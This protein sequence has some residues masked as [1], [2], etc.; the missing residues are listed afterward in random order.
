M[1]RIKVF[2]T[3]LIVILGCTN[4]QAQFGKKLGDAVKKSAENT[5]IRKAEQKTD[6]AVSKGIDKAT[7]PETYKGDDKDK[8][9]NESGGE[10]QKA[11]ASNDQPAASGGGTVNN[12]P[13][14]P[15][16]A[17]PVAD[18]PKA[19]EMTYAKS[20]FVSGDEIFFEDN[21]ANEK[22]GEFPSMW[23]LE[24][25]NAE[26]A[27][28]DGVK[29][30]SI[31]GYTIIV[32]LMKEKNYLPDEFTIE[33][34]VYGDAAK[35][36]VTCE[37][38]FND[39]RTLI[40]R[41]YIS[42]DKYSLSASWYKPDGTSG[43]QSQ[44]ITTAKGNQ[45]HHVSISFNKRA[46]KYYVDGVRYLN[47]PNM[48]K[49]TSL[50]LWA[51]NGNAYFKNIRMAKGAV[52]LYD[53][54]MSDGKFITYGI[55]FDVGKSIIKPESMG[56]IN[57]IVTLMTE[58]PDLKF[59]VEGHT[60]A[61]GNAASNQALSEA[62]SKAIVDKLVEMGVAAGRLSSA[63]KG[64]TSPIA[65]NGTDEGRAKNRRVEFVKI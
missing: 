9:S 10:E 32:P 60:D 4:L 35:G 58:S 7:N 48:R 64:Q 36:T 38:G 63:G 41:L 28:I 21:M 20:D 47:I 34:D 12:A 52:P 59:S 53:R 24:R 22:L 39:S 27:A 57:R 61:T 62:R 2:L 8:K 16:P 65:D 3:I 49:P 44:D 17:A 55:T 13:A 29:C 51:D 56:E 37:M 50:W 33:F 18:S 46:A 40:P 11:P 23:D 31:I 25:G 1:K 6:Q 14:N 54:M 19:I 15:A 42:K 5:T 45:W 43:N 26:I 30:I